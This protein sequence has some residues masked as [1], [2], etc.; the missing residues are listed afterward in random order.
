MGNILIIDDDPLVT[1]VF[2]EM[3]KTLGHKPFTAANAM[4]GLQ[5][6]KDNNIDITFVDIKMPGK[7]GLEFLEEVKS[8]DE[9]AIVTVITGFP[10][11]ETIT[12]TILLNGFTYLEKPIT[13]EK[14]RS[15]LEKGFKRK[16][17]L[18]S[19]DESDSE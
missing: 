19:K 4:N 2:S 12:E 13:I 8:I 15:I 3:V 18:E 9:N 10:S 16:R 17:E 6:F 5:A 7:S 14:L 1:K 11:S